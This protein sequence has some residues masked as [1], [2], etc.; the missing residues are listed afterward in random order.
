MYDP[1]IAFDV[2]SDEARQRRE[3]G[4]DV[5]AAERRLAHVAPDDVAALDAVYEELVSAPRIVG[6]PYEEPYE[7]ADIIDSCPSGLPT[8]QSR[9]ADPDRVLGSWLG[10][11]AGCNLGK[12]IED[13]DIWTPAR[14]R[15]YLE[16]ADSYPLRYYIPALNPMPAGYEFREC[17]PSTTR[18]LID[19]SDRDDDI[20]YS[21]L[22]LHLLEQ[23]GPRLTTRDIGQSWLTF[24]PYAR[25]YTAER[26]TYL[27]LLRGLSEDRTAQ[28]RNPYREWIGALI[29]GDIFGWTAPGEPALAAQRSFVD[30]S[31]S[32]RA[33]GIYG[34]MW[35]SA[36]VSAAMTADGP[37]EVVESATVVVP[38]RSRLAEAIGFVRGLFD[39]GTEFDTAMPAIWERYAQY[40]WVHT[41]NNA[42]VITAGLLWSDGD[43]ATAVGNTVQSGWDTDSNGATVG[44]VMGALVGAGRLPRHFVEPL[45]DR[46]RS[47]VFG[48]DMSTISSLADRTQRLAAALSH[49]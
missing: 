39:A 22:G 7:L 36:L 40:S 38:A 18:G 48:Y 44:S 20:D 26:A 3:S 6:W 34:E 14:I 16:K 17:W 2:A 49:G 5:A 29:R 23:F 19:G 11:V 28:H 37:V 41:I 21:I 13:G 45:H 27:N 12:P 46:T 10:R 4:F 1:L 47:A 31:L 25:I 30:A 35:S 9:A 42:A 24:L 8:G 32:H 15:T 33:N 43:Y